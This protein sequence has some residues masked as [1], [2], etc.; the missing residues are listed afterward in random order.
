MGRS[1]SPELKFGTD[2][3][4]GVAN[5]TLTPEDALRLGY[6]GARVFGGPILIGRDTRISGGMLAGALAAGAASGGAEV[7]DLGVLSTPGVAA[8]APGLEASAAAVVSA[9]HNPYP[10]NGIKFF[11]GAGRKLSSEKETEI[12]RLVAEAREPAS[13]VRPAADGVG[14]VSRV[15]DAAERYVAGI[16]AKLRPRAEGLKVQLD[17]ANGAAYRA[18]PLAFAELGA[19]LSVTAA[20][21]DGT[22]INDRCGS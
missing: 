4:R 20:E 7:V 9:S 16:L 6:A 11:S 21:P 14:A 17:C 22:N 3:V 5:S 1:E 13:E 2:G 8:L 15:E 10:D 18:A 12:E 19:D